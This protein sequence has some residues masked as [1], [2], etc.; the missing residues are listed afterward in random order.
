MTKEELAALLTGSEYPFDLPKHLVLPAETA[1]LVVVFGAS[2]DLIEFRGALCEEYGAYE[3]TEILVTRRGIFQ[4]DDCASRCR[5][6]E[7]ARQEAREGGKT[8]KAVWD[9]GAGYSW[10]YETAIPHAT[11]EIVEEGAPYCRG[12]VFALSEVV[13]ECHSSTEG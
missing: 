5:Y 7:A 9:A 4:E 6:Y 11:F 2:D 1:G 12:I 10:L 13:G 8:I 3:G